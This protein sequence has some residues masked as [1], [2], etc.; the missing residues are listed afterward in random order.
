M[1]PVFVSRTYWRYR[2]LGEGFPRNSTYKWGPGGSLASKQPSP[3]R[4]PRGTGPYLLRIEHLCTIWCAKQGH[5]LPILGTKVSWGAKFRVSWVAASV[6]TLI[7][8]HLAS[9]DEGR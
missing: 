3:A 6:L 8:T 2:F 4:E 5:A 7:L 1:F 9:Q